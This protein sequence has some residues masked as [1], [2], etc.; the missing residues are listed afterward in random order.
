MIEFVY[1]LEIIGFR[2]L[3]YSPFGLGSYWFVP[4]W[5]SCACTNDKD[6]RLI[7]GIRVIKHHQ[8]D[9]DVI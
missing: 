2:I 4:G 1:I 7:I 8:L 9:S 3:T 6:Y 5:L